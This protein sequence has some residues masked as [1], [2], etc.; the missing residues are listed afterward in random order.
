VIKLAVIAFIASCI[1]AAIA[2]SAPSRRSQP[3]GPARSLIEFG[4]QPAPPPTIRRIRN[5]AL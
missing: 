3:A 1:L 5:I 2:V 4:A